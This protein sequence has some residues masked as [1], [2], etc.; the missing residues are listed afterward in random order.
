MKNISLNFENFRDF[1]FQDLQPQK[2]N[3]ESNKSIIYA[4]IRTSRLY[5]INS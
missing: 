3:Q 1:H 5:I 4:V 2:K